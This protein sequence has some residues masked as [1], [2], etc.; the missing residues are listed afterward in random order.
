MALGH[1]PTSETFARAFSNQ[2]VDNRAAL[3]PPE[4]LLNKSHEPN[5]SRW[6]YGH[7][8]FLRAVHRPRNI[9]P[10]YSFGGGQY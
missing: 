10:K 3:G 7:V 8:V 2:P 6:G 5:W 1:C 4:A 9:R